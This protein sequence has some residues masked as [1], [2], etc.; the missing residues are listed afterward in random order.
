M[1]SF[2][3]WTNVL[4]TCPYNPYHKVSMTK[5]AGHIVKC[6]QR[7]ETPYLKECPY[8]GLHRVR[9][10]EYAKHIDSCPDG[11]NN[12]IQFYKHYDERR[13]DGAP[14]PVERFADASDNW[15]D[16]LV[17]YYTSVDEEL[18]KS[19]NGTSGSSV[20]SGVSPVIS[21][22]INPPNTVPKGFDMPSVSS[23]SNSTLRNTDGSVGMAEKISDLEETTRRYVGFGR[24][25]GRGMPP[26]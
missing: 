23:Y 13:P 15:D 7:M 26:K 6:A 5:F 4:K 14:T 24:G 3:E 9:P 25:I 10:D 2:S 11:I 21:S 8:N 1:A 19:K 20:C 22:I 18:A 16:E 12:A 17:P